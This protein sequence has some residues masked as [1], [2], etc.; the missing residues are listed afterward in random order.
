M[1][2]CWEGIPN[3]P[4]LNLIKAVGV[5]YRYE[6]VMVSNYDELWQTSLHLEIAHDTAN[7]SS[8]IPRFWIREPAWTRTHVSP[9]NCYKTKSKPW[10]LAS[11]HNLVSL[12][13]SKNESI[14]V[15][16]R[17]CLVDSKASVNAADHRNS[18]LMLNKGLSGP[19]NRRRT[20]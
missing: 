6:G 10:R 12:L 8:C 5:K 13:G 17:D 16:D 18:F 11:V 3:K 9:A 15:E 19:S 1:L 7:I 20:G 14:G 4:V 2:A